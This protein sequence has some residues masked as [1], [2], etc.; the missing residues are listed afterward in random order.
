M[1]KLVTVLFQNII[2]LWVPVVKLGNLGSI[3]PVQEYREVGLWIMKLEL[4]KYI[5]SL[6]NYYVP[7]T[8]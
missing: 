5:H 3:L 4:E 2:P 1:V 7:E 6:S 8:Y